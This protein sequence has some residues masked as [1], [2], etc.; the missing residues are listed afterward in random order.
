MTGVLFYP[1]NP[2]TGFHFML[3]C[4]FLYNYS[5]RLEEDQFKQSPADHLFMLLFNWMCCVIV[6][7]IAEFP[8][9]LPHRSGIII[10]DI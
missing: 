6:G 9:S 7:I 10:P 5:S 8:V 2:Q 3:N 4:F 1:L